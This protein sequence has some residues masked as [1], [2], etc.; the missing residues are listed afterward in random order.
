MDTINNKGLFTPALAGYP[1]RWDLPHPMHIWM[2]SE[3]MSQVE[4]AAQCAIPAAQYLPRHLK[5]G[6]SSNLP[7]PT[8]AP[9]PAN[10]AKMASITVGDKILD[11]VF[12]LLGKQQ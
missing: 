6:S 11:D 7:A 10:L 9:A 3:S 12:E 8:P 1:P 2:L 4:S 5:P